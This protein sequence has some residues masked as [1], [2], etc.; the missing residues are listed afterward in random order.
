MKKQRSCF[1]FVTLNCRTLRS[2]TSQHQLC[3]TLNDLY[4]PA[5]YLQVTRVQKTPEINTLRS[6]ITFNHKPREYKIY[7]SDAD[8]DGTGGCAVAIRED[9]VHLIIETGSKGERVAQIQMSC[10]G[11][12][13][14]WI[15]TAHAPVEDAGKERKNSFYLTLGKVFDRVHSNHA[16]I[17]GTDGGT[18]FGKEEESNALGRWYVPAKETSDSG[19]RPLNFCEALKL[20]GW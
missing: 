11:S 5:A 7:A 14:L 12:K 4:V 3:C 15:I 13:V 20:V 18:Q 19:C 1:Y 2:P 9:I 8:E 6:Q 17:I 10:P 16:V